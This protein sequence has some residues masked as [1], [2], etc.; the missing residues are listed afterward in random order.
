MLSFLQQLVGSSSETSDFEG[1]QQIIEI[2]SRRLALLGAKV[3]FIPAEKE[4]YAPAL[5]SSWG[6]TSTP[7]KQALCLVSHSDTV[8][9]QELLVPFSLTVEKNLLLG[10]GVADN[11]GGLAIACAAIEALLAQGVFLKAKRPLYFFISSCEE[12]GSPAFQDFIKEFSPKL[13]FVL[14]LEP[15]LPNGDLISKRRGNRYYRLS[16][17][18]NS[19]HTGRDVSKAANPTFG[20]MLFLQQLELFK[21]KYPQLGLS[22]NGAKTNIYKFN[23]SAQNLECTLDLRFE[24]IKLANAFHKEL[25]EFIK[26]LIFVSQDKTQVGTANLELIDDCPS[27]VSP[28]CEELT[29]IAQIYSHHEK[30]E[31]ALS[32][33]LGGSDCCYFYRE[34]LKIVDGLGARGGAIHSEKEFAELDSLEKRS[35]AL[36]EVLSELLLK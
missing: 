15:A 4:G 10:G 1:N 8:Y 13:S 16:F 18:G 35:S 24:D 31:V 34:G 17:I 6:N 11:K 19:V 2:L 26:N 33:G 36:A 12:V 32:Q 9:P 30:K 14:G 27:F 22:L 7:D 21:K 3:E 23:M 5:L 28:H 25:V 20:F 29:R